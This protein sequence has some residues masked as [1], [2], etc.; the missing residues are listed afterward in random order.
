MPTV[1]KCIKKK[2]KATNLKIRLHIISMTQYSLRFLCLRACSDYYRARY[3]I[4]KEQRPV[5]RG[6]RCDMTRRVNGRR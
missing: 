1:Y 6:S 5:E 3:R 4:I 2:T